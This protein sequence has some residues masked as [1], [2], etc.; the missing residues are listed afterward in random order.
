MHATPG[1]APSGPTTVGWGR[2]ALPGLRPSLWNRAPLGPDG[3]AHRRAAIAAVRTAMIAVR[4][5]P[6]RVITPRIAPAMMHNPGR[7]A[8]RRGPP[9]AVATACRD[10]P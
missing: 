7:N 4:H 10:G 2:L 9:R 8:N 5:T 6:P 3:A 1:P